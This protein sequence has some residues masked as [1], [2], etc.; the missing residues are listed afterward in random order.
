[1]IGQRTGEKVAKQI[2]QTGSKWDAFKKYEEDILVSDI[3]IDHN[4]Q[5][6]VLNMKKVE[7]LKADWNPAAVGRILISRRKDRSLRCLDGMHRVQAWRE[8]SDNLGEIPA[9]IYEGLSLEE[10]AELFLD[11]NAGDKPTPLDR[12]RVGVVGGLRIPSEVDKLIHA[13][14]WAVSK[15]TKGLPGDGTLNCVVAL[16]KLYVYSETQGFETNLLDSALKVIGRAWGTD[17]NAAQGFVITA[18]GRF[19]GEYN[20][21]VDFDR[22]VHSLREYKGGIV[23]MIAAARSM[24]NSRNWPLPSAFADLMVETY[25]KGLGGKSRLRRWTSRG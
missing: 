21:V 18:V 19:M 8:L 10:E 12:Y 13:Y 24:A 1:M 3:E 7:R 20:G 22:L 17:Q 14:G 4:V 5:R 2:N 9:E 23:Q 25:N 6:D 15:Y 11:R 16:Q